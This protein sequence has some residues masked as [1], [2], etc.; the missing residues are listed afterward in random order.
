[1]IGGASLDRGGG[2]IRK[3]FLSLFE[4]FPK[5]LRFGNFQASKSSEKF[6]N[7]DIPNF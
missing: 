3:A 4:T 6:Q 5:I 7:I 1:M 2:N